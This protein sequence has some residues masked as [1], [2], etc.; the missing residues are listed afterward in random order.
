MGRGNSD[1][2]HPDHHRHL[3]QKVT[4]ELAGGETHQFTGVQGWRALAKVTTIPATR[5][6]CTQSAA[7]TK[8]TKRVAGYARVST[9]M[10]EQAGSCRRSSRLL[11]RLHS[12][13]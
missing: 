8:T 9:D 5:Q 2:E 3:R 13:P 12:E 4:I 6:L 1:H 11:H 7:V 10:E